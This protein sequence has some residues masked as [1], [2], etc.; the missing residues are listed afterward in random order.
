VPP[1]PPALADELTVLVALVLLEAL[2]VLIVPPAPAG[3]NESGSERAPH[4]KA[5]VAAIATTSPTP[6]IVF[7]ERIL[8]DRTTAWGRAPRLRS[9]T[10][11]R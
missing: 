5:I 11:A 8:F 10:R 6:P 7:I 4:P 2:P 3:S 1:P 9:R